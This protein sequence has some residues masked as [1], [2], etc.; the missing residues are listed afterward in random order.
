MASGFVALACLLFEEGQAFGK[1]VL[2]HGKLFMGQSQLHGLRLIEM[3][4]L[5]LLR[6]SILVTVALHP[7]NQNQLFCVVNISLAC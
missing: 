3:G 6:P 2:N 1:K 7:L 4:L 5:L